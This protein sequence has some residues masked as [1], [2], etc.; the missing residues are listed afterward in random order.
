[1]KKIKVQL[2]VE[3]CRGHINPGCWIIDGGC[4]LEFYYDGTP[5]SYLESYR[6]ARESLIEQSDSKRP[7]QYSIFFNFS[8]IKSIEEKVT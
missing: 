1:M 7:R 8:V 5:E 6:K 3:Y 4:I 2:F